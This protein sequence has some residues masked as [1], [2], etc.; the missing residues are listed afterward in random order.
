MNF[1][2]SEEQQLLQQ[3]LR[4]F[5]ENEC[6]AARVRELFDVA[7]AND[8]AL[9]KG[10]AELGLTGLLVP[11]PYGGA[12]LALL[13][14]V[15]AAEVLGEGATPGPWAAHTLAC[16]AIASA[17]SDAQKRRWLPRLA[18]GEALGTLA[19]AEAGERWQPNEWQLAPGGDA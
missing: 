9:W 12:G 7:P 4:R 1:D 13:D 6:P 18:S 5:L 8:P 3:T 10:L 2:L 14:A 19:L 17:G 15:A 11:E 16:L